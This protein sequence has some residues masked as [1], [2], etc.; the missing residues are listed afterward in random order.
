VGDDPKRVTSLD[1]TALWGIYPVFRLQAVP[2]QAVT[3][4]GKFGSSMRLTAELIGAAATFSVSDG[5]RSVTAPYKL[6]RP[7][8]GGAVGL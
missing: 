4:V 2:R 1:P 3:P 7:H 8:E 5:S 6:D